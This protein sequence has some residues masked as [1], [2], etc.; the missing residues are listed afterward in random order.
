M[1]QL[2]QARSLI[3]IALGIRAVQSESV[4]MI[5]RKTHFQIEPALS[6]NGRDT[7]IG[8]EA[9]LTHHCALGHG[10]RDVVPLTFI[11]DKPA[12]ACLDNGRA[13]E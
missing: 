12:V 5:W 3:P 2:F 7:G 9:T 13:V 1:R 6:L 8:A 4:L 11:V 10:S